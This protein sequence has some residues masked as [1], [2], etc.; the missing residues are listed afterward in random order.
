MKSLNIESLDIAK[1]I[2]DLCCKSGDPIS[3]LK[4]QKL[5]YYVQAWYVTI[6]NTKIF[7][8]QFQ[9]WV[10]GPV[11]PSVYANYCTHGYGLI[12]KEYNIDL[13]PNIITHTNEVLNVFLK[14]SAFELEQMTHQ[15]SPW[16]LARGNCNPDY[17]STNIISEEEMRNYYLT[18]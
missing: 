7:N 3:H 17:S 13:A 14:H 5:L 11:L 18:L 2:I 9:A 10:H 15:E 6:N 1:Y 16:I 4:L 8:E 12:L